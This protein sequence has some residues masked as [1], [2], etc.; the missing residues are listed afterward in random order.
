MVITGTLVVATLSLLT[1]TITAT[2]V[3]REHSNAHAWLQTASDMLY[4]RDP[5]HCDEA[6]RADIIAAY[7]TTV[8]ETENPEDWPQANI[9]VIDLRFW[10]YARD[11]STNGVAEGW[12][13]DQCTTKLQRVTLQVSDPSGEIVEEVEVVIGGE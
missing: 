3:D 9:K 1:G 2:V 8:R 12:V 6:T 10:H 13:T 4:A 11:P 7:Q 5:L